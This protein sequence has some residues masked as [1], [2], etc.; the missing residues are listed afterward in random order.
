MHE[1]V[2]S[3]AHRSGPARLRMMNSIIPRM[4]QTSTPPHALLWHGRSIGN[5]DPILIELVTAT[6]IAPIDQMIVDGAV[7]KTQELTEL[8]QFATLSPHMGD[9]KLIVITHA[10]Q[11][12]NVVAN[13]LLKL[14]EEPPSYLLVRINAER[15]SGVLPT[16][17]SRCQLAFIQQSAE[18][19]D[20]FPLATIDQ[21]SITEQFVLAEKLAK[22][23][24]LPAIVTYWLGELEG[25]LLRGVPVDVSIALGQTLLDHLRTNSNRR[26]A[27]ESWFIGRFAAKQNQ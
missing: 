17:R 7:L 4:S 3:V 11:L 8:K 15:V 16:I 21:I 19:D 1:R 6:N 5:D 18:R 12:S 24:A 22:D 26:L 10:D 9:H 25:Q 2:F 27:L 23:E 14:I 13:G 20:R